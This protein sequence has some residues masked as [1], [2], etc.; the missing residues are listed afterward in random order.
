MHK[1]STTRHTHIIAENADGSPFERIE[2]SPIKAQTARMV[3]ANCGGRI[4]RNVYC[5]KPLPECRQLPARDYDPHADDDTPIAPSQFE[6]MMRDEAAAQLAARGLPPIA[7]G[8]GEALPKLAAAAGITIKARYLGRRTDAEHWDHDAW[9]VTLRQHD[10]TDRT[11]RI[12]YRMGTGHH[13]AAPDLL[14]VLDSLLSDACTVDNARDF[15]DWCSELGFDP[16]SRKA[17][18]IYRASERQTDRVKSFLGADYD[19]YLYAERG[20]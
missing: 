17:E 7:G 4:I 1:Q 12:T 11:L 20:V 5:T 2:D 15:E 3:I 19:T 8:S 18:R 9:S 10:G 6:A 16:D 14:T 13:G